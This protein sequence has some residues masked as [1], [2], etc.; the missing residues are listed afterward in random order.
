MAGAGKK[1]FTAGEVLTASDVNTYLMEQSVMVFGGTAARSSAIPTPSEGMT[2]YRTDTQQIESYDGANWIGM[3]GLQLIKKQ[4]IGSG[5]SSVIVTNAFSATYVNYLIAVSDVQCSA[6]NDSLSL[7]LRTGSTTSTTAYNGS[8]PYV[9]YGGTVSG[10]ATS[11][12]PSFN[13]LGRSLGAGDKIS[14]SFNIYAPFLASK[15]MVSS[16]G[17][18]GGDLTGVFSGFHNVASSYDQFVLG[19]G[20][21]MTGG[22]IY[23]YGYGV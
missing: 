10:A 16:L 21:T 3:S 6:A 8:L 23:V 12:G 2:S 19:S 15:T 9:S 13:N 17:T 14:Y 7:Q 22:T 5:V 20:G 18:I 1:T 11:N 4:T